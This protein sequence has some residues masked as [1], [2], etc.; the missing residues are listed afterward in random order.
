VVEPER[1]A[2][3][4]EGLLVMVRPD[5]P[6]RVAAPVPVAVPE[7][8][9]WQQVEHSREVDRP[10]G[11]EL[12]RQLLGDAVELRGRDDTAAA[13][14]GRIAGHRVIVTAGAARRAARV[15]PEG[16]ALLRRAADLA[17]RLDVSLVSLVDTSGADPLPLSEH[18][19]IAPAIAAAL[20]SVL[21]CA[22]PTVAVV[23]GEGGSGGA[24]AGAVTDVVGVTEHGWFAALGPEGAGAA[25]RRTPAE[26]ADL[27]GIGPRDLL[28]S[29]FAD[30][31]AP[32]DVATLHDWI[33]AR[34]DAL[35]DSDHEGRL[36]RRRERWSA[37]LPGSAPSAAPGSPPE[38]A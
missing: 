2:T 18:A 5:E 20:R 8:T 6:E 33:G 27:M 7:R 22:A 30:A 10:G 1:L 37:P 29:G 4:L 38:I 16:F 31:L 15:S 9:G 34:L 26:A 32:T 24:L 3:W 21:H 17:S 28:A 36:R 25:L 12:L 13:A 19:G 11:H 23:H 35:R 14:L